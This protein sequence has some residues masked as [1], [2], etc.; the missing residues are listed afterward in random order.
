M[1]TRL[2][3]PFVLFRDMLF[4]IVTMGL[5]PLDDEAEVARLEDKEES[6]RSAPS[7]AA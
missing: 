3:Y 2:T 6:P 5:A 1:W 7:R 4:G